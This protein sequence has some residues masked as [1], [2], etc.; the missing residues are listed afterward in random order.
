[1]EEE[2]VSPGESLGAVSLGGRG[3]QRKQVK[4]KEERVA[5]EPKED[6]L[7]S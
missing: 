1:M 2:G 5:S 4:V 7:L 6:W 3:P